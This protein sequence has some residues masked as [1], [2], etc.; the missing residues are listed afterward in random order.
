[1]QEQQNGSV[2][3]FKKVHLGQIQSLALL[4]FPLP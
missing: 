4:S 2:K 3:K 1:M